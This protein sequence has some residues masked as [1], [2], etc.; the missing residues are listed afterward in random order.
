MCVTPH[1]KNR[2]PFL[3]VLVA[4]IV[5]R[6]RVHVI[7][8]D[9]K[10]GLRVLEKMQNIKHQNDSCNNYQGRKNIQQVNSL[11]KLVRYYQFVAPCVIRQ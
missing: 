2:F 7:A 3:L 11:E 5:S 4:C 9:I 8:V 1:I 6:H 10:T